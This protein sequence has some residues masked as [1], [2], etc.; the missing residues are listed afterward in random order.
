MFSKATVESHRVLNI[1]SLRRHE[2]LHKG[3]KTYWIWQDAETREETG[4][5]YLEVGDHAL[6]LRYRVRWGEGEW[7]PVEDTIFLSKTR[8]AKGGVRW[9]FVC[10]SCQ[11]RRAKLYLHTY[12]RCRGCLGLCYGSQLEQRHD[13]ILRRFFKRRQNLGGFGGTY[14]PFPAKPKWMRWATYWRL[15]EKDCRDLERI[16]GYSLSLLNR[17]K[18]IL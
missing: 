4:R 10:P 14:E 17:L 2:V 12:F 6:R 18:G 16:E 5:I 13:R 7:E 9:W 11:A 15:H 8:P 1:F 3:C